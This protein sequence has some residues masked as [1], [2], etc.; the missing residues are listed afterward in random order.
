MLHWFSV[1]SLTSLYQGITKYLRN[2]LSILIFTFII[3]TKH[4]SYVYALVHIYMYPIDHYIININTFVR[5]FWPISV[6]RNNTC[7][8]Q[9]QYLYMYVEFCWLS[10]FSILWSL[11]FVWDLKLCWLFVL[12]RFRWLWQSMGLENWKMCHVFRR[13]FKIRASGRLESRWVS[14]SLSLASLQKMSNYVL[15]I[16]EPRSD[17]TGLNDITTLR[18]NIGFYIDVTNARRLYGT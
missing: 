9:I 6:K 8:K 14:L 3:N 1:Q 15:Y 4:L 12:Q 13:T 17:N 7:R 16:Y 2:L 10:H 18:H 5:T 11:V